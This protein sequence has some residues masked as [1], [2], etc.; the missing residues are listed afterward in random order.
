MKKPEV[1]RRID[2]LDRDR[3]V[4]VPPGEKW[5]HGY[6][7][8]EGESIPAIR[9]ADHTPI[10]TFDKG[11]AGENAAEYLAALHNSYPLL[12]ETVLL[13]RQA[14]IRLTVHHTEHMPTAAEWQ[15]LDLACD[16][17]ERP[18]FK[19]R[20]MRESEAGLRL[21]L[22]REKA[23]I[24]KDRDAIARRLDQTEAERLSTEK[25]LWA[26]LRTLDSVAAHLGTTAV[27]LAEDPSAVLRLVQKDS[28]P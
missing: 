12:A 20:G 1:L 18:R 2:D 4:A 3:R 14:L 22:L 19:K 23:D 16:V 9:R 21:N 13:L 11:M 6:I 15:D 25:D 5:E 7:Q 28:G 27:A 17:L 24:Q 10:A 8:R 26:A